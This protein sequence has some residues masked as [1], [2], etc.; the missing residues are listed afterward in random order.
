MRTY[1]PSQ[2]GQIAAL[3][4]WAQESGEAQAQKGQAGL[5]ARF[6]READP[7]GVLDP[8]ERQ[9]RAQ[10]LRKLHMLRLAAKSAQARAAKKATAA[11]VEDG[12]A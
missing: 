11:Q 5:L 9:R 3:S 8:K 7:D 12:A 1:T 2:V 4:R 6:E 10:N